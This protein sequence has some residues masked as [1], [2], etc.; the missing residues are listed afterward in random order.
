MPE[1]FYVWIFPNVM[2]NIYM[3]Q[4][5]TNVVLPLAHDR[6][7][8]VFEWFATAPP[9]DPATDERWSRL[10][11]FSDEIQDEDIEICEIVQRN[12]RSRIYDRGRS[13]AKR[14]NGA[15][16][17]SFAAS[18]VSDLTPGRAR[19]IFRRVGPHDP[20]VA[21]V[22]RQRVSDRLV[23]MAWVAT[24][25]ATACRNLGDAQPTLVHGLN[26]IP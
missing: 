6:T 13:S 3:G 23:R 10:V 20:S 1:A 24:L 7:R 18:R 5:Q 8:V 17:F 2:L 11:A 15:H 9:A 4:M 19:S 22:P 26:R 21:A 14:E 25:P 16:H 12:L